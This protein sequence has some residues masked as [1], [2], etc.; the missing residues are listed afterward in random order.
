MHQL[1]GVGV[2]RDQHGG[3]R[4]G[5]ADK[6]DEIQTSEHPSHQPNEHEQ[7]LPQKAAHLHVVGGSRRQAEHMRQRRCRVVLDHDT[8]Q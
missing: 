2:Y 8:P 4:H 6:A 5:D 7:A 1:A 3:R